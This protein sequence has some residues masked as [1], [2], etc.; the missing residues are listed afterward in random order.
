MVALFLQKTLGGEMM[1]LGVTIEKEEDSLGI[2]SD[3]D[4]E[5]S[6]HEAKISRGSR[7]Q[8]WASEG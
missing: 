8:Q 3:G 7:V 1:A 4:E 5:R 6:V 2:Y